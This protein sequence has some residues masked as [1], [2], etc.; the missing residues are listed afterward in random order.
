MDLGGDLSIDGPADIP[1]TGPPRE[2][3]IH[4]HVNQV[5]PGTPIEVQMEEGDYER[6]KD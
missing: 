2:T 4:W 3:E 6:E 5:I 1:D